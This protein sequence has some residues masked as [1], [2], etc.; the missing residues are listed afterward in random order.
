MLDFLRQNGYGTAV[1]VSKAPGHA[2]IAFTMDRYQHVMP[3]MQAQAA[4]AI[5]AA[6]RPR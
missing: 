2:S 1:V 4:D 6:L 3:T 5:Q